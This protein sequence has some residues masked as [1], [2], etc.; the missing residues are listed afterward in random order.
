MRLNRPAFSIHQQRFSPAKTTGPN[1]PP[2]ATYTAPPS[3]SK[4]PANIAAS[5]E[6]SRLQG[7]L[8]QLH[9][10]HRDAARVEAQWRASAKSKLGERF[11]AVRD[12]HRQLADREAA[13]VEGDNIA[14]LQQWSG[15]G[16]GGGTLDDRVRVLDAVVG[17]AWMMSEPGGKYARVVR[18]FERWVERVMDL[19]E[20][21]ESSGAGVHGQSVGSNSNGAGGGMEGALFIQ[22]LDAAWTEE[23]MGMT[24]KL[25]GWQAQ[26]ESSSTGHLANGNA[27]I[28]VTGSGSDSR[29]SLERMLEGSRAL[30]EDMLSEL[31]AMEEIRQAALAREED[32]IE[33]MNRDDDDNDTPRAGAVWRA[34]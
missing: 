4:L 8:L 23:C 15:G 20:A 18:R 11:R 32:W 21:R 34:M 2:T 16:G 5:A 3:P 1:K 12:A 13:E 25:E 31:S 33:R 27:T 24:H 7:E 22:D 10:L 29:S 19:E 30:I 26:L 6:T 28:G 17:G 14:A 9:L